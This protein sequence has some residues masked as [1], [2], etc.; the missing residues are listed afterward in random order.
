[1]KRIWIA[2]VLLSISIGICTAEQI[3]LERTYTQI[4]KMVDEQ[5]TDEIVEYWKKKNDILYAFSDHK[6][7]DSL[8]EAIEELNYAKDKK[9]ALTEVRAISKTF[10]E[11]QRINFS[12]I[13]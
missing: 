4:N 12:N 10:Y 2:V 3:Y 11:N 6:V 13:F 8:S 7:L 1:M 9:K 5:N